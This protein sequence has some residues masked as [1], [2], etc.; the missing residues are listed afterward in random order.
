MFCIG[1][2]DAVTTRNNN[3]INIMPR[4]TKSEGQ[5]ALDKFLKASKTAPKETPEQKK[6]RETKRAIQDAKYAA[7]NAAF[8]AAYRAAHPVPEI[9][10]GSPYQEA[11]EAWI[12]G[13]SGT[14]G[15]FD[16]WTSNK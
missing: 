8:M 7:S 13:Q 14:D 3:Y 1:M 15:V 6:D 4:Q 16:Y 5:R 12:N 11:H 9:A 10:T 2:W